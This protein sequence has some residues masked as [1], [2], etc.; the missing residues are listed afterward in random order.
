MK[1]GKRMKL[2]L[3]PTVAALSAAGVVSA[4]APVR[5]TV[6]TGLDQPISQELGRDS[7]YALQTSDEMSRYAQTHP[8]DN[9]VLTR[10][11]E[12]TKEWSANTWD[13][14]NASDSSPPPGEPHRYGRAGGYAGWARVEQIAETTEADRLETVKQGRS[15]WLLSPV[16]AA[17]DANEQYG[18]QPGRDAASMDT[19]DRGELAD[20]TDLVTQAVQVVQAMKADPRM[21]DTM[22]RAKGIF[23]VPNYGR[24]A[25][26]VGGQG[27]EGL[28]VVREDGQWSSPLFY[29]IGGISL[30]L[31]A[32]AEGGSVAMLLMSD[33]AVDA[34]KSQNNFSLNAGA[35]LTVINYSARAEAHTKGDIVVWSSTKGAYAGASLSVTDVNWD[36]EANRAYYGSPQ[37]SAQSVLDG[38]I[39]SDRAQQLEMALP[40]A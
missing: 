30:G 12:Q 17:G 31:Q 6:T 4:A 16:S 38:R 3:I 8:A 10:W 19:V 36:D 2:W 33:A 29:N 27:G 7:V 37:V 15:D 13:Q 21:L 20:T 24:G 28:V 26:L 11:W 14:L 25:I 9:E 40:S 32:G 39:K 1:A 23:I 5:E 34:F 22:Q 35:G 18:H